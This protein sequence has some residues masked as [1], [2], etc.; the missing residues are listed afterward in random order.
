MLYANMVVLLSFFLTDRILK[1]RLLHFI[2]I[3]IIPFIILI[4]VDNVWYGTVIWLI[5]ALVV[6]LVLVK[7]QL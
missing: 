6:Y 7:K 2:Y 1:L 3:G 4:L 5:A